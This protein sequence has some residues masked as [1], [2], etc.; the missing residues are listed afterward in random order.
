MKYFNA[1]EA[2][3]LKSFKYVKSLKLNDIILV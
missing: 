2:K 1:N 3:I